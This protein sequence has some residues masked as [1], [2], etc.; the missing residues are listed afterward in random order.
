M[1][2]PRIRFPPDSNAIAY[3]SFNSV[4]FKKDLA[5][6]IINES[7]KGACFVVNKALINEKTPIA[8][9]QIFKAQIGQ[10]APLTAEVKWLQD[11]DADLLKIGIELLE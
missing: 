10:L 9:G 4:Q 5:A 11:V 7:L 3:L 8:I 2:T 6:L 1:K